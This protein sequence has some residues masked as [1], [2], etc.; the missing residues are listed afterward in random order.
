MAKEIL[1]EPLSLNLKRFY[2]V[3][4]EKVWG[5]WIDP[6]ALR[7]WFGQADAPGWQAEMDVRAGGRYRLLMQG[8]QGNYYEARGIY[9]EV[10][11]GSRLVFTWTWQEGPGAIEALIT[12]SMK[13]VAGG[14][15]LEFT[16][17]P[18]ADPRERDA[19]RADFKRLGL[20]LQE[21]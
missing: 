10:V 4:P 19:W 1:G 14:T 15:E 2:P 7:T 20:L 3:A 11:P 5:A 6:A 8:P 18:V 13:P 12:V 16:L 21:K 17:D 9:R